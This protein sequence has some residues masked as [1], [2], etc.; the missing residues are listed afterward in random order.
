MSDHTEQLV[1]QS[2]KLTEL[3]EIREVYGMYMTLILNEVIRGNDDA[4]HAI[5][6]LATEVQEKVRNKCK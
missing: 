4:L 5:Q 2:K 3:Q 1:Y 6:R